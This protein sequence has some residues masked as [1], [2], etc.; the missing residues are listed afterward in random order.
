[1]KLSHFSFPVR[2]LDVLSP[3][4]GPEWKAAVPRIC[5]VKPLCMCIYRY[6]YAYSHRQPIVG[7]YVFIYT[8]AEDKEAMRKGVVSWSRN[9]SLAVTVVARGQQ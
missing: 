1:M 3:M 4:L 2:K 5:W 7:I 9:E 6:M 8:A